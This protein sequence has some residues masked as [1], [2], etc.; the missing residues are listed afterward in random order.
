MPSIPEW[1][2]ERFLLGELP[3]EELREIEEMRRTDPE[4]EAA[5]RE[6]ERS[7][8]EILTAYP[9]DETVRRIEERAHSSHSDSRAH[10][11]GG[12]RE[13]RGEKRK[14]IIPFA[15]TIPRFA[16]PVAA[17]AAVALFFIFSQQLQLFGPGTRAPV[18]HDQPGV[19]LKG[20][21]PGIYIFRKSGES[22]RPLKSGARAKG[23]DLL[24]LGFL[25]PKAEHGIL[26]SVDGRGTLTLH[27][28]AS[29]ESS[30]EIEGGGVVM[31]DS[32][33]RLDDAPD[34]ERF[35]LVTSN[36]DLEVETVLQSVRS[37]I[38]TEGEL[39]ASTVELENMD[40]PLIPAEGDVKW[41]V[42]ELK[43]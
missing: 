5:I 17:A 3:K 28:P 8:A 13:A 24:Q 14:N 9:V 42:F 19:R 34:Y 37:S 27:Y 11:D 18:A 39:P 16:L 29:P 2:V 38:E 32:S 30:T 15:G 22:V 40:P 43:K 1:K 33:Y 21:D 25:A 35:Y 4:L 41:Y 6:I 12:E 23:G 10:E 26:F 20:A 36:I 7:N 31:L